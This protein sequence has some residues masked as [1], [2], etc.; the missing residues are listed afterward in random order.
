[1]WNQATAV[2]YLNSHASPISHGRCAEYTRKAIEAGG[3]SLIRHLSAKD[4]GSSL[5]MVGFVPFG[6]M[7]KGYLLGDVAVI[8]PIP[9]HPNGHMA[10]FNGSNWVSDFTQTHGLY[11]GPSYRSARPKFTIYRYGVRCDSLK[12]LAMANLA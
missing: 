11:P 8:D 10:M 2:K 3:L 4:Y 1:M 9:G 12:P 7:T 6:Q 5:Q